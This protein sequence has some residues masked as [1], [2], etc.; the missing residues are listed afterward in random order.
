ME[1]EAGRGGGSE[2][3]GAF[4]DEAAASDET[5]VE[6]SE[7]RGARKAGQSVHAQKCN[8]PRVRVVRA[9]MVDGDV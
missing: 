7:R 5:D 4:E 3:N 9:D 1:P 8:S 2:P 6:C